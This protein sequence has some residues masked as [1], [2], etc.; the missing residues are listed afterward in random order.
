[1]SGDP[2][3]LWLWAK[4]LSTQAAVTGE[5][6]DLTGTPAERRRLAEA[7]F[8]DLRTR[9]PD[10]PVGYAGAADLYLD[11]AD[12]AEGE[13]GEPFQVRAWRRQAAELY[14]QARQRSDDP[15][16][17]AGH[18]RALSDLQQSRAAVDLINQAA[19]Q[20]PGD[21][22]IAALRSTI[23]GR[24]GRHAEAAERS[25]R[26]RSSRRGGAAV[27]RPSGRTTCPATTPR[28]EYPP[29]IVPVRSIYE[30]RRRRG[31]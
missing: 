28:T 24:A 8:A 17:A 11:W 14:A 22:A 6:R 23:L 16:L 18:A 3:P 12:A 20:D 30:Y 13:G 25:P 29:L 27:S 26:R 4:F 10:L 5:I 19:T 31:G 7:A 21:P 2:T 1:M 15:R 9:F